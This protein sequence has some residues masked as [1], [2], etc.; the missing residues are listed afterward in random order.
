MLLGSTE[1]EKESGI[2][3]HSH[4][5]C[6]SHP[7]CCISIYLSHGIGVSK[8]LCGADV[9]IDQLSLQQS[10]LVQIEWKLAEVCTKK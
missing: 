1:H 7:A 6:P 3:F 8:V 9:S 2:A 5:N 4:S 10:S